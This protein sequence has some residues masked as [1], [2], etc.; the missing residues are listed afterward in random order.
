MKKFIAL[1]TLFFIAF[2]SLLISCGESEPEKDPV[3]EKVKPGVQLGDHTELLVKSGDDAKLT[4]EATDFPR[5]VKN[6]EITFNNQLLTSGKTLPFEYSWTPDTSKI[7]RNP[8]SIK[9]TYTDGPEDNLYGSIE[10]YSDIEPVNYTYKVINTYPHDDKAYTQGLLFHD[11]FLYEGTGQRGASNIR[12]VALESGEIVI[13]RDLDTRYF[14]E[15]ITLFNDRFY[16]LSWQGRKGWIYD[17]DSLQEIKTF[18]YATEGWG[19]TNNDTSLILS[20]GT[21]I[22]Y[23]LDPETMSKKGKIEVYSGMVPVDQL[24]ELEMIDGKLYANVWQT[25]QIVIIDP[26]SGKVEGIIN[27]KDIYADHDQYDRVLNGIAWDKE[28]NRLF[29]T[30]KYWP[31]LYEIELVKQQ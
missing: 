9:V 31:N 5:E 1:K 11:G 20:D 14:G 25:D 22:I 7:G 4:L 26:L 24:N 12:K 8:L 23:F 15:G 30:G 2:T 19:L 10:I 18:N 17:K 13:Q 21:N 3:A 6:I 16:Q 29:V 27:L 28:N